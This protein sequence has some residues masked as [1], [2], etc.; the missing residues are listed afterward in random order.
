MVVAS[1][2]VTQQAQGGSQGTE[3]VPLGA[4]FLSPTPDILAMRLEKSW[5]PL[6]ILSFSRL[7]KIT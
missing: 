6:S 2:D 3:D 1:S 4:A 7:A 5:A